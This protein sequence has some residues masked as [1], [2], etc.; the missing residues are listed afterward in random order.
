M[1]WS[2]ETETTG[3]ITSVVTMNWEGFTETASE[4]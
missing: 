2:I 1:D 3:K 4:S